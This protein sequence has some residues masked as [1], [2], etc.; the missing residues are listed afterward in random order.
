[1]FIHVG[2]PKSGTSF[3]QATLRANQAELQEQGFLYP[4]TNKAGMF[5]AALDV[6]GNHER[7]RLTREKVAGTWARM[8]R[9]ALAF[10][11]TTV[12]SSEFFCAARPAQIKGA[13]ALLEDAEVH[14]IVTGRDLARQLPAEWQEGIKHGRRLTFAGF[15]R[16]V[17]DPERSHPHARRFWHYQDLPRVMARWADEVSDPRVHLVTCPPAGA[18]PGLLWERFC[19]V[20]G[21][22]PTTITLPAAGS[23]PSLG[24]T[25]I[26]VLRRVNRSIA[27]SENAQKDV[28]LVKQKLVRNVLRNH[29]SPRATTP[30][31]LIP[32]LSDLAKEWRT[33]LE[34]HGYDIVGSLDD[35]EPV[36]PG[37]PRVDPDRV[38]PRAALRVS[39]DAITQLL[40][41]VHALRVENRELLRRGSLR[42]DLLHRVASMVKRT[43]R[44]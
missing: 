34:R 4:E 16:R 10:D 1:M 18:D 30:P 15:Q 43:G 37:G 20:I 33:E 31:E 13:V 2:V 41:E 40:G 27:R 8:C 25:E 9:R 5:H 3:I 26:D 6:N 7:W 35:L 24:V 39:T 12:I 22:D 21:L 38:P 28:R 42:R 11:G 44:R 14:V 23:N 36:E 29:T 19:S 17:L 32:V